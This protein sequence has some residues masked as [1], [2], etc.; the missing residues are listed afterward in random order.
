MKRLFFII[1]LL[2]ISASNAYSLSPY[3]QRAYYGAALEP[4]TGVL[5]GLGQQVVPTSY[6]NFQIVLKNMEDYQLQKNSAKA[7]LD[8]IYVSI[9]P[10]ID[11]GYTNTVSYSGWDEEY[12]NIN[13]NAF[14]EASAVLLIS[15]MWNDAPLIPNMQQ[16]DDFCKKAKSLNIPILFRIEYEINTGYS[17]GY[18]ESEYKFFWNRFT[19]AM[20]NNGMLDNPMYATV[21]CFLSRNFAGEFR[22]D[23]NRWYPEINPPDW[24]S[25]DIFEA[26]RFNNPY[27]NEFF[28]YAEE[29]LYKPV[30]LAEITPRKVGVNHDLDWNIFFD[31]FFSLIRSRKSVKA[32]NYISWE[33]QRVWNEATYF[34]WLD[35]TIDDKNPNLSSVVKNNYIKELS[36]DFYYHQNHGEAALYDILNIPLSITEASSIIEAEDYIAQRGILLESGLYSSGGSHVAYINNNDFIKFNKIDFGRGANIVNMRLASDYHGGTVKIYIDNIYKGETS[37]GNTGGW[38]NWIN[39]EVDIPF[40]AGVHDV[41]FV[42]TGGDSYLLNIDWITFDLTPLPEKDAFSPIQA[43]ACDDYDSL[44][45][46]GSVLGWVNHSSSSVYANVNF[47]NGATKVKINYATPQNNSFIIIK[48]TDEE[49]IGF[50]YLPSTGTW[51]DYNQL[52]TDINPVAGM[53]NIQLEFINDDSNHVCNIDWFKFE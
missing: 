13:V 43:E 16:F 51:T 26:Y 14:K 15:V 36:N 9:M 23:F 24:L 18:N 31:P 32:F 11:G 17:K 7:V 21:L 42:F 3:T 37:I 48:T 52:T 2:I 41:D 44:V 10:Y 20:D 25:I 4:E 53:N 35:S 39:K 6:D 29:I 49:I 45:V 47:G 22:E 34:D 38:H 30:I 5:H 8:N 46:S 33:W 19:T 40:I 1:F 50:I 12:V 28:R 27:T